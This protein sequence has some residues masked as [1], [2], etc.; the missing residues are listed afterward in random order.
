MIKPP[1]KKP[2]TATK[3][4]FCRLLNP[5]MAWP[6]VQ[7]PAYRVPKPTKKPAMINIA[8]PLKVTIESQLKISGGKSDSPA[9][10]KPMALK[11][12]MVLGER[13]MAEPSDKKFTAIKPPAMAPMTTTKFQRC[14]F[15]SNLKKS[16][17]LPAPPILQSVLRFD[18]MP[19]DFPK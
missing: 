13:A 7:P 9:F 8:N 10:L 15:Q 17:Y 4:G 14:A 2:I 18:D 3:E 5:E 6:E 12:S 19:N 11:S 16:E 1:M